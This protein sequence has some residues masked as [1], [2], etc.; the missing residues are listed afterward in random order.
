LVNGTAG[1][2]IQVAGLAP[3]QTYYLKVTPP[4]SRGGEDASFSLVADF[5]Q[6][7]TLLPSLATGSVTTAPPQQGYALYVALDQVFSFSLSAT[8]VG[9]P[10]GSAVQMTITDANGNVVFALTAPAGQTVTGPGVLL[11][12]GAYTI[13]MTAVVPGG[14]QASLTFLL[15]GAPLSDPVGPVIT[16]PTNS[17]MYTNPGN[18]FLY[19]YPNG[20]ISQNPFLLVAFAL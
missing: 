5:N 12:P 1:S 9:A 2:T 10:A 18:P 16:D 19:Y 15:R 8:G 7:P 13:G 14:T 11:V 3:G 4:A 17:P 20:T 6:V